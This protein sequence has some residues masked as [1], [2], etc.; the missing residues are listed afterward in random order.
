M[1][2]TCEKSHA[3]AA[4]LVF[5]SVNASH[6]V[7]TVSLEAMQHLHTI[8]LWLQVWTN[9]FW[10]LVMPSRILMHLSG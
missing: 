1:I 7:V 9:Y 3:T 6:I 2:C 5:V 10:C 4:K 8:A